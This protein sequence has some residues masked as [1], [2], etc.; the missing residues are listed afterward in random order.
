MLRAVARSRSAW[1]CRSYSVGGADDGVDDP[2]PAADADAGCEGWWLM[3]VAVRVLVVRMNDAVA[4][5]WKA[6]VNETI[7]SN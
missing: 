7:E 2:L 5:G 6:E 3:V 1:N 4:R